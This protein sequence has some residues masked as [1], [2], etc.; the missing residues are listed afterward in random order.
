[1]TQRGPRCICS[2]AHFLG[3]GTPQ[4]VRIKEQVH[5]FGQR[6][7]LALT[8]QGESQMIMAKTR[9]LRASSFIAVIALA[10]ALA[11]QVANIYESYRT[12]DLE[13]GLRLHGLR[14]MTEAQLRETVD[15]NHLVVY[16]AGSEKGSKYLLDSVEA[17]VIVLTIIPADSEPN[18]TRAMHPQIATYEVKDAFQAVLAGGGNPDVAGFINGDGNSVFYSQLDPDNVFVGVRG[19]DIELQ[20]FDPSPGV[21]LAL[22]REPGRLTPIA[23]LGR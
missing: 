23:K 12:A 19:R 3:A 21:S 4:I 7:K 1:M 18:Q 14:V 20:I 15:S 2:I 11:I 6:A 16:W 5:I 22:A 13:N 10:C 8:S 17:N 9:L